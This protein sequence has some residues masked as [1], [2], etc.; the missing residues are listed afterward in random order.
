ML[1][2]MSASFSV[3]MKSMDVNWATL[4]RIHDFGLSVVTH[5]VFQSVDAGPSFQRR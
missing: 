4:I 3:L 2:W 1:I 5:G